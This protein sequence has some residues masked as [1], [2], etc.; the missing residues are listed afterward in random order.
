M[1]CYFGGVSQNDRTPWVRRDLKDHPVANPCCGKGCQ[2]LNQ[3]TQGPIQPGF[4]HLQFLSVLL[5]TPK[6]NSLNSIT[7]VGV[8]GLVLFFQ[9]LLP[10]ITLL[11]MHSSFPQA[12]EA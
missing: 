10:H 9:Q 3:A 12:L 11:W 7:H 8:Y 2:P 4:E 5:K 1:L 6:N